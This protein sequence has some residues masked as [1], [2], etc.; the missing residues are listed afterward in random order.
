M[1]DSVEAASRSLKK[2]DNES[3]EELI[4]SIIDRL[5]IEK[6]FANCDITFKDI[7]TIK[8]VFRKMLSS[9]F[10]HRIEYPR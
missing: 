7:T 1:A 2:F 6:Q 9:S 4:E 3:I 8:K 10:H 5:M